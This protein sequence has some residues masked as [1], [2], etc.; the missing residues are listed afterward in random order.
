MTPDSGAPL[1]L[2]DPYLYAG[3]PHPAYT[4]LRDEAPVYW[5][6]VSRIWGISRYRDVLASRVTG[7][8]R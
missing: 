4:W 6:P 7:G 5:D 2:L 8:H 1:N 3:D